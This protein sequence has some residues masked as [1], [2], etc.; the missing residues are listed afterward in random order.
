MIP[1]FGREFTKIFFAQS[2]DEMAQKVEVKELR[3]SDGLIAFQSSQEKV[4]PPRSLFLRVFTGKLKNENKQR[5]R[6]FL[7]SYNE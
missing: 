4:F 5:I 3:N 2:I 1:T 6:S 7:S